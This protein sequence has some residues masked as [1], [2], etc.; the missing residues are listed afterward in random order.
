MITMTLEVKYEIIETSIPDEYR[1][2][3]WQ[4]GVKD[5]KYCSLMFPVGF[6]LSVAMAII[7]RRLGILPEAINEF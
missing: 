7:R 2:D 1:L 3:G 4:T 5:R 6:S